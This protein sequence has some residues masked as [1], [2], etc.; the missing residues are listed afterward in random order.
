ML[1]RTLSFSPIFMEYRPHWG[2]PMADFMSIF[3]TLLGKRKPK[4]ILEISENPRKSEP[5]T[6]VISEEQLRIFDDARLS[7]FVAQQPERSILRILNST[8]EQA[9][10]LKVVRCV[11]D[12]PTLKRII[13]SELDKK[14]KRSAEK[15]LRETGTVGMDLRLQ[16]LSPW[17]QPMRS[18]L[19]TPRWSEGSELLS[20]VLEAAKVDGPLDERNPI[21]ADFNELRDRLKREVEAYELTCAELHGICVQLEP[22][23]LLSKPAVEKLQAQWALLFRKYS[24]PQKATVL[25]EYEEVLAARKNPPPA[26]APTLTAPRNPIALET[27]LPPLSDPAL[28]EIRVKKNET[29]RQ[30]RMTALTKLREKVQSVQNNLAHRQAGPVLRELQSEAASLRN[31]RREFPA[32]L[33]EVESLLKTLSTKR[34]EV[35]DEAKWDAWARTD[36]AI[37]IQTRL[38]ALI[39][40]LETE[41]DP[42]VALKNSIGLTAQL[43]EYAQEMRALGS[44]ER[45]KDHKIWQQFK[46]VSDRGWKVCDRMRGLVLESVKVVLSEH[47]SR[48]ID[49]NVE[50]LTEKRAPLTFK[51][52]AFE[53]D[54]PAQ[55]KQLRFMWLEIGT[56]G[57][58]G[59]KRELE[60]VFTQLFESYFRQLNLQ[61]G[62]IQRIENS[63]V[64]VKR[65]LLNEMKVACEGKS[66]LISRARVAK[67]LEE[68]WKRAPLPASMTAELQREFETYQRLL[69]AELAAETENG[70]LQATAI[71]SRT[72]ESLEKTRTGNGS[73]LFQ[74]QKAIST[75]EN[76]LAA[77]EKHQAQFNGLRQSPP[78][79]ETEDK[80]TSAQNQF[81]RTLQQNRDLLLECRSAATR[82]I[83]ARA[84]ERDRV[85]Q[86]AQDLA[87]SKDWDS[88]SARFDELGVLWKKSGVL[89][90]SQDAVFGMLFE[91]V[92]RFFHYRREHRERL[93]ETAQLATELKTTQ[94]LIFSLEALTRLR[95]S[96]GDTGTANLTRLPLPF[97]DEELRANSSGKLLESGLKYKQILSLD[98][99]AG[100]AKETRKIMDQWCTKGV[101]EA[102]SLPVFWAFY[103]DRVR[104][105]LGI[106]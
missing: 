41:Q 61:Q 105:L 90:Q 103:L 15:K 80:T 48:P 52:S 40:G 29:D 95:G 54:V 99:T 63:A 70:L 34:I 101:T 31:W 23:R 71:L 2:E 67:G 73:V 66:T 74:A 75:L 18:F 97:S 5:A 81:Q 57:T 9:L 44:L 78:T 38:E 92:S 17:I 89:G 68:K 11:T 32:Q 94:A 30:V 43:H 25:R 8:A 19:G 21:Y 14:V 49:F 26:V 12:E 104:L 20:Q 85:V 87:L 13:R 50:S 16:R 77:L 47:T 64:Q 35:V 22:S 82:E 65:D 46:S 28:N 37:R 1:N 56:Q 84:Q 106:Y 62:Q 93:P 91:N 36:L 76:E 100:I 102:D 4:A 79:P 83:E 53:G 24:F 88:A 96:Q 6:P 69:N 86:E 45:G 59:P 42:V 58:S 7:A 51:A 27:S 98:P 60:A 55:V 10:Q 33:D 3:S 39:N 72:Q